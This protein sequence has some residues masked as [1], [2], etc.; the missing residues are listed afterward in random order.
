MIN[1]LYNQ[2]ITKH[3]LINIQKFNFPSIFLIF[4]LLLS[5]YL[6]YVIFLFF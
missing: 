2:L 6:I 5:N 3:M 4:K 1:I